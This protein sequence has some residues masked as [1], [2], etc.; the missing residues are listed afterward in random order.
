MQLTL[1]LDRLS[2]LKKKKIPFSTRALP[3]FFSQFSL[4]NIRLIESIRTVHRYFT[5]STH[6]FGCPLHNGRV[7]STFNLNF[8]VTFL[9]GR[10]C[11]KHIQLP[12]PSIFVTR[13]E[14]QRFHDITRISRSVFFQAQ[15]MTLILPI[16]ILESNFHFQSIVL[17]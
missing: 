10:V 16:R 11:V 15:R 17:R 6:L 4:T 7:Y 13:S 12:D 9:K 1:F 3:T 2:F 8:S 14:I 5:F